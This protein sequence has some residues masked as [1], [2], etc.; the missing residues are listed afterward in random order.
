MRRTPDHLFDRQC[1]ILREST[2]KGEYNRTSKDTIATGLYD[3]GVRRLKSNLSEGNPNNE[4]SATM[5]VY[6]PYDADIITGDLVQLLPKGY[7]YGA[8]LTTI[9][10]GQS[11]EATPPYPLP[12]HIEVELIMVEEEA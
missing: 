11:Y 1:I 3:C 2:T 6:L 4:G 7:E 5:K 12:S 10:E 9:E 8:N